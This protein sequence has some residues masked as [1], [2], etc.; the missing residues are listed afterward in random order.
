[1]FSLPQS[2]AALTGS[3][4]DGGW[5]GHGHSGVPE[6]NFDPIKMKSMGHLSLQAMLA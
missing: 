6:K 5:F 4:D 1:M 2:Q 3:N